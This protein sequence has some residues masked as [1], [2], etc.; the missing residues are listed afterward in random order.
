[1]L[2]LLIPRL[3]GFL[4][5][6]SNKIMIRIYRFVKGYLKI[7]VF[8]EKPEII[9]NLCMNEGLSIWGVERKGD[10]IILTILSEDYLKLFSLRKSLTV[11]PKSRIISKCGLPF[12]IKRIK[13]RLGMVIGIAVFI[14]LNIFLSSFIDIVELSMK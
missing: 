6:P 1:M 11:K 4:P 2:P 12:C 8:G 10:C 9:I 5:F 7:K 14:A 13:R 3:S